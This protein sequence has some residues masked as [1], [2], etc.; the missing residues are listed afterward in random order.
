MKNLI[1]IIA[2]FFASQVLAQDI[3][4]LRDG[5]TIESKVVEVGKKE[6]KYKKFS[7]QKGPDYRLYI[8]E[9]TKI[10]YESGAED[11]FY[12]EKKKVVN[13][14]EFGNNIIYLNVADILFQN[15]TVG[16][17]RLIGEQKK[18]GLRL[19]LSFS[20]YGNNN[21]NINGIRN[22]YNVFY[23]GVELNYYPIGQRK[24]TFYFGPAVRYGYA[25]YRDNN[26][27]DGGNSQVSTYGYSSVLFQAGWVWNPV[28][29]LSI[30]SSLGIGSRRYFSTL[31]NG[32]NTVTTGTLWFSFGYRF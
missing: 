24:L 9:V 26:F 6:I 16:Y 8:D 28:K 14:F 10:A 30:T 23:S 20:L 29:E 1:V 13:D 17:E 31:P 12:S 15:V 25:R 5:S 2:L 11:V 3:I 32:S 19:P 4:H 18:L 7:N 21:N 22:Y 27:F